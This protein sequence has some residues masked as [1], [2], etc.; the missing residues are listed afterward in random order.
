[1]LENLIPIDRKP[2]VFLLI[3]LRQNLVNI[4]LQ[5]LTQI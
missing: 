3:E 2:K 5:V 1:M 4:L